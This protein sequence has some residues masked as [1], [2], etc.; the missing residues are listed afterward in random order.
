MEVWLDQFLHHLAAERGLAENTLAA[1]ARDIRDFSAFLHQEQLTLER[2]E[3]GTV[4]SYLLF[5]QQ[6]GRAAAT[7]ARRL[8]VLR[9]FYRFLLQEELVSMDPIGDLP[10]PRLVR[11]LPRVLTVEEVSAILEQSAGPQPA[12]LRDRAMLELDYATGLRVSE[13]LGLNVSDVHLAAGY[14]RCLGKGQKERVVPFGSVAKHWLEK[15]LEAGRPQLVKHSRERGL[16][17]NRAGGRLS[18]QGFWKILKK[19]VR[20]AS[21]TKDIS[22][23]SLRHSFATHLLEN[24]ADLRLVQELLGHADIS[25]TQIYTHLTQDKLREVYQKAHP[26]S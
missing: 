3:A 7:L 4:V 26:R 17:L 23:H 2:V 14:V 8:A 22:P 16:F 1:Y 12:G 5:L 21:I 15:Y 9:S 25:T 19:Y 11:H 13:L 10:G 24:G 20:Q 6:Q 18:R